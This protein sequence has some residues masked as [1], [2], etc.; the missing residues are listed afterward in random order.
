M[1]YLFFI[2]AALGLAGNAFADTQSGVVRSGNQ[3]IPGASVVAD[4]GGGRISTVTDVAGRFE[5]GGLPAAP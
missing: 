5:L 4:C 1:V 2:F 3:T